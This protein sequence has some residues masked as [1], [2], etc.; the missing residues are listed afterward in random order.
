MPAVILSVDSVQDQSV[1]NNN[2]T[3]ILFSLTVVKSF[4]VFSDLVKQ[5]LPLVDIIT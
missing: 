4:S 1:V 2:R 3:E 5:G